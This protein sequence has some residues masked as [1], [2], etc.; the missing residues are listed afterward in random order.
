MNKIASS[1]FSLLSGPQEIRDEA[2][3]YF[4]LRESIRFSYQKMNYLRF[5]FV[6]VK[7]VIVK[8][9]VSERNYSFPPTWRRCTVPR[10]AMLLS[11]VVNIVKSIATNMTY[12]TGGFSSKFIF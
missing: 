3:I 6:S 1:H 9:R 10:A 7:Y 5:G 11:I 12:C 4:S 8:E 2:V